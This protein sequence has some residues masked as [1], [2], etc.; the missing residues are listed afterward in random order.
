MRCRMRRSRSGLTAVNNNAEP[1]PWSGVSDRPFELRVV[2]EHLL[3]QQHQLRG[4]L[5]VGS[6]AMPTAGTA[7]VARTGINACIDTTPSWLWLP[8]VHDRIA[9]EAH[10]IV[11]QTHP[12]PARFQR[13]GHDR[14]GQQQFLDVVEV[15]GVV[16]TQ[17]KAISA[18]WIT[19]WATQAVPSDC[20]SCPGGQWM[21]TI[22]HNRC[23]PCRESHRRRVLADPGC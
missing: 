18:I 9:V 2:F 17:F 23:C 20:T 13:T 11:P 6:P 7:T 12:I 22:E 10:I 21:I 19:I 3:A 15:A 5:A 1:S 4:H 14:E 8:S 16:A